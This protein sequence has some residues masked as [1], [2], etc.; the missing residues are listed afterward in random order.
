L[1]NDQWVIDEIKEEIKRFQEVNENENMTY[2]NLWDT[3]K[4]ILRGKVIAMS[5][6]IKRTERSQIND[7][8]LHLKLLEKQEQ[9]NLK[10]AIGEKKLTAEVNE[11]EANKQTN[12]KQKKINE[13]K[14]WFFQKINKIDKSLANL[15]KMRKENTQI[16][17][18]RNAK[19]QITTNTTEI[20]EF[21]RYYF[22]NLYSTK[23]ENLEEMDSV[24]DTYDNPKLKQENINLLKRSRT[25]KEIEAA[26]K[27]LPKKKSPGLDGFSDEFYQIFKEE[28]IPTLLKLFHE[29]EREGKQPNLFYEGS[30]TLIQNQAK[31]PKRRTKSQSP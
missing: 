15:T 30:I 26:V 4:V 31:T 11:I 18:I 14:S 12:K 17:K 21:I 7:F 10:T 29:T 27:S 25:Q 16:S 5:A 22:E 28:L 6:Y 13:T 20:Q 19:G 1:L 2:W 8:M 3:A 23:F 24:L 9:A